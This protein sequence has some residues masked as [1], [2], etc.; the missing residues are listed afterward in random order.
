MKG[1]EFL[2]CNVNASA[3]SRYVVTRML[4]QAGFRVVEAM[5]GEEAVKAAVCEGPQLLSHLGEV[6]GEHRRSDVDRAGRGVGGHLGIL[7]PG[8]I[9]V[10]CG[11]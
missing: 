4:V 5:T 10:A 2:I 9:P 11:S 3:A 7:R 8:R 1:E 6:G